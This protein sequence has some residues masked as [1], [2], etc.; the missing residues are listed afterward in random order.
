MTAERADESGQLWAPRP[1]NQIRHTLG[2]RAVKKFAAGSARV[3]LTLEGYYQFGEI[4][5]AT[6]QRDPKTMDIEA[7][8]F[9]IDGGV[10][11]PVP[12]APRLSAEFNTASG[13]K[14]D[15]KWGLRSIVPHQPHS[16][17]VHGPH[18]LEEHEPSCV[19]PPTAAQQGQP[20]RSDRPP[21][22]SPGVNRRRVSCRSSC[23]FWLLVVITAPRPMLGKKST[24]SIPIS[25]PPGTTWPGKSAAGFSSRVSLSMTAVVVGMPPNKPGAIPN[26]G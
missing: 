12:M 17:R 16:L 6:A 22:F 23:N 4:G 10:T 5:G 13:N 9:H 14:G 1:A 3:D 8:A 2:G 11:L 21:V 24:W 7:Y 26:S 18:V 15:G 20:L 19:R 25:S